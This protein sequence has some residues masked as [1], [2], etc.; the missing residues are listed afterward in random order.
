MNIGL[1][2]VCWRG[3]A[4]FADLY[5]TYVCIYVCMYVFFSRFNC[6]SNLH[7]VIKKEKRYVRSIF[8][9]TYVFPFLFVSKSL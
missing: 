5:L 6:K 2:L 9:N 3:L 8:G 1:D 7:F 4:D